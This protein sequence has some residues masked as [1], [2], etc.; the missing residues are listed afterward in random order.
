MKKI[1]DCFVED[2][3]AILDTKKNK[4][5]EN[6]QSDT[7]N[8]TAFSFGVLLVLL[9]IFGLIFNLLND[10]NYVAGSLIVLTI[11]PFIIRQTT[12]EFL[13]KT[14]FNLKYNIFVSAIADI[15]YFSAI[16]TGIFITVLLALFSS[17]VSSVLIIVMFIL[18]LCSTFIY[19]LLYLKFDQQFYNLLIST[20]SLNMLWI[21]V[22]VYSS[23]FMLSM[24]VVEIEQVKLCF[25]V[26]YLMMVLI[27]VV[28]QN[29]PNIKYHYPL[30]VLSFLLFS[31]LVF[32]GQYNDAKNYYLPALG[33]RMEALEE[34]IE[35]T[36][37]NLFA[38]GDLTYGVKDGI[39]YEYNLDFELINTYNNPNYEFS[40]FFVDEDI[41]YGMVSVEPV[42]YLD[43]TYDVYSINT[44]GEVTYKTQFNTYYSGETAAK[45]FFYDDELNFIG[46]G[47]MMYQYLPE[48]E[49]G[50]NRVLRQTSTELLVIKDG[51]VKYFATSMTYNSE[52]E[53]STRRY[54]NN[55]LLLKDQE[56]K[57]YLQYVDD[58]LDDS[59]EIITYVDTNQ[60]Y[61]TSRIEDEDSEIEFATFYYT[62]DY[63]FF[64]IKYDGVFLLDKDIEFQKYLPL[65]YEALFINDNYILDVKH[66]Y[67]PVELLY[68]EYTDSYYLSMEKKYYSIAYS[69]SEVS[70]FLYG[71]I[72]S[73][74]TKELICVLIMISLIP[75]NLP[76]TKEGEINA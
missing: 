16:V 30:Y 43:Y 7:L 19:V 50:E 52:H 33:Y 74:T 26:S 5:F 42:T 1:I 15:S 71:E 28:K 61:F 57:Y 17:I 4:L 41:V 63:Y 36:A 3:K 11:I 27:C 48:S 14:E 73:F 9:S 49:L 62:D 53:L 55:I 20:K 72:K 45:F 29:I 39:L 31:F 66:N 44:T 58:Y 8:N 21:S 6:Y 23:I 40:R 25:S 47:N 46:Y 70:E 68:E 67:D 34:E 35:F 24:Y 59:E 38:Y 10:I 2:Y 75:I 64:F 76:F 22:L 12:K 18:L 13:F 32:N 69:T 51:E 56:E 60:S 65:S 54:Y 37:E